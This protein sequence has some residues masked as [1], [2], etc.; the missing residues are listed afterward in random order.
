ME[1][2]AEST[3]LAYNRCITLLFQG[4]NKKI[5]EI[6]TND[7]RYYL[8]IYQERRK[9]SLAYLETLRHNI[10]GFF[11]W[12]T[13]EGY[14]NRN[15]A[16]RLKRVKVPQKIKKPY[17]AQKSGNIFKDVAKTERDVWQSWSSY[18]V[19]AGRIEK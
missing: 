6:T 11:S 12:A 1:N 18:T 5:H 9:I 19:R 15:P 3:L 16:R 2:C 13:D 17:T 10:S 7:L 4:I 8:A 14:I